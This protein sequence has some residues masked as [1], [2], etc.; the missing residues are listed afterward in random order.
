[1]LRATTFPAPN[2]STVILSRTHTC[3]YPE[4][5]RVIF[6]RSSFISR[7]QFRRNSVKCLLTVHGGGSIPAA[8][9]KEGRGSANLVEIVEEFDEEGEDEEVDDEEEEEEEEEEIVGFD[10]MKEWLEKKPKGFGEGKVYD[11]SV[12]DKLFEEIQKSKQ[13]QA[14]N[15]KKLKSNPIKSN[16]TK[17]I[18]N[19]SKFNFF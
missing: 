10:E 12:E 9:K 5:K 4:P 15:L 1:M 19:S 8:T 2:N 11:T 18:G 3:P 14:L 7:L 6:P 17:K 16:V 13:A